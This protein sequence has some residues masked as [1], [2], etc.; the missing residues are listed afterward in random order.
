[1]QHNVAVRLQRL[2]QLVANAQDRL[3]IALAG[4]ALWVL[5]D[6]NVVA[7]YQYGQP[8]EFTWA[9]TVIQVLFETVA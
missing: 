3:Q 1:M 9:G 4:L 7:E 2:E 8:L 5:H 6:Q